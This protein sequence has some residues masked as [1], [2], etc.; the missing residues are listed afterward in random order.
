[1]LIPARLVQGGYKIKLTSFQDRCQPILSRNSKKGAW[2]LKL[3][4][5]IGS[6]CLFLSKCNNFTSN[7]GTLLHRYSLHCLRFVDQFQSFK[8]G[9][10]I[11]ATSVLFLCSFGGKLFPACIKFDFNVLFSTESILSLQIIPENQMNPD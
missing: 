7:L 11:C 8:D 6:L 3:Y 1:M 9:I 4:Y 2:G 10:T 5:F